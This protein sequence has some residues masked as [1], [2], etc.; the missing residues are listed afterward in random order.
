MRARHHIL[1]VGLLIGLATPCVG[2]DPG[3]HY[4]PRDWTRVDAAHWRTDVEGLSLTMRPMGGLVG[5]TWLHPDIEAQNRTATPVTIENARLVCGGRSYP[6]DTVG[7]WG[8]RSSLAPGDSDRLDLR[9]SFQKPIHQVLI[10]P[11]SLSL[12]LRLGSATRTVLIP[13]SRFHYR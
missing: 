5:E 6:P 2:C 11:V 8:P 4:T 7:W 9:W 13:M 1:R 10:P 3:I 12:T